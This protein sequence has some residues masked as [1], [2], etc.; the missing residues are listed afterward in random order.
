MPRHGQP[1]PKPDL[2]PGREPHPYPDGSSVELCAGD[3]GP[4]KQWGG[5][6]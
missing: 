6:V 2:N 4:D 3:R 5:A 1:D